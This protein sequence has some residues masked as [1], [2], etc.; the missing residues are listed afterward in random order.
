MTHCP[1]LQVNNFV[2]KSNKESLIFHPKVANNTFATKSPT[3]TFVPKADFADFS[4]FLRSLPKLILQ[5]SAAFDGQSAET[6][7]FFFFATYL[8]TASEATCR[9]EGLAWLSM[10]L[11]TRFK[12]KAR[13]TFT[14][15]R[16]TTGRKTRL[17]HASPSKL[18]ERINHC[19]E[20]SRRLLKN[21]N[22]KLKPNG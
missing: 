12:N 2:P 19:R 22:I 10:S 11:P 15:Q 14:E 17:L 21:R 8:G 13:R 7:H 9:S 20:M 16:K 1:T 4:S 3:E 6:L 5:K 18:Y